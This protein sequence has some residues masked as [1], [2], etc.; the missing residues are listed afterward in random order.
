MFAASRI[1]NYLSVDHVS[2]H[3]KHAVEKE[4]TECNR[5]IHAER[6]AE[7][8]KRIKAIIAYA[9]AWTQVN[10]QAVITTGFS[11]DNSGCLPYRHCTCWRRNETPSP[12]GH[13]PGTAVGC[14]ERISRRRSLTSPLLRSGWS[15]PADTVNS[16]QRREARC[17]VVDLRVTSAEYMTLEWGRLST[18]QYSRFYTPIGCKHLINALMGV[19]CKSV[20]PVPEPK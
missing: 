16:K 7:E 4:K 1:V 3:G 19:V 9:V 6:T 12:A 15:R 8:K 18:Y 10:I 5:Q 11:S 2:R 13:R 20:C 14:A 17:N